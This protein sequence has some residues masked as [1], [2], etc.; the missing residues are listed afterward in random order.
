MSLNFSVEFPTDSQNVQLLSWLVGLIL[1]N[2]F[3]TVANTVLLLVM[4]VHKSLRRSSSCSL[5]VHCITID[6]YLA[7]VVQPIFSI[8]IY[9]GPLHRLPRYFCQFQPLSVYSV[10]TAGMYASS[11]LAIH[12]LFATVWPQKF[13]VLT[14][15]PVLVGLI[16]SPWILALGVNI[17]PTLELGIAMGRN[18]DSGACQFVETGLGQYPLLISTLFAV[19]IPTAVTGVCY[20]LIMAKTYGEVRE[21]KGRYVQRRLEISRTLFLSFV[22][23]CLTMYPPSVVMAFYADDYAGHFALQLGM[24]WLIMSFSAMNPV[25]E[26]G[27]A[28]FD[29]KF[30]PRLFCPVLGIFLGQL[31][32]LSRRHPEG[33]SLQVENP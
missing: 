27:R 25:N 18:P 28:V 9:L 2:A 1:T 8:P 33:S 16:V 29:L 22:W 31:K 19:Y 26:N 32:A 20:L 13:T 24:H 7:A 23:H 4:F 17:F 15:K 30:C 12:R 21:K 5:I 11:N 14:G 10:Y 6:L 3:G